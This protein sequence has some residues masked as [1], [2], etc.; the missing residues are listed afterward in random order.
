MVGF[1]AMVLSIGFLRIIPWLLKL[2][3]DG[4]RSGGDSG[5]VLKFVVGMVA[6]AALGGFFLYLQRWLII[7]ASR[8]VEFD[9]KN[10]LFK[11]L[12]SMDVDYFKRKKTGELL[13]H[14]TNDLNA[15]RDV[16]GPGIMYIASM[17]MA[18]IVSLSLM[19][20][21]D[22]ILT[23]VAFSPYPLISIITIYFGRAMHRRSRAVQDQFGRL[24]T[25]VQEDIAGIRVIRSYGQEEN[26]VDRFRLESSAYKDA[27]M[28]VARLRGRFMAGMGLLAGLGL[29]LSLLVGGGSV[30]RGTLSLGSL[31]AFTA[32]LTELLWPV[33]AVGFVISMIQRG[34]SAANRLNEVYEVSP[35]ILSGAITP[36]RI[37]GI[38]FDDVSFAYPGD[39]RPAL[40]N[41]RFHV[42]PGETLG[43]V[44]RTGSGKSTILKLI[45]RF[46]D[47]T[48]GTIFLNDRD[49]R[50]YSIKELR[51]RI[52]YAPQDGFLFS[53][54]IEDNIAYGIHDREE[55]DWKGA[56]HRAQ[57]SDEIEGFPD[58][59]STVVGERGIALSGGQRQRVSLAR[60]LLQNPT[61]LVLD[62]TLS[63]VDAETEHAILDSLSTEMEHKTSIIVSHRLSAVA[64]AD[65]II[66]LDDGEIIEEGTHSTLLE[67]NGFYAR[68]WSRQQLKDELEHF[69]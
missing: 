40:R 14:F 49:L 61:V 57:L 11:H 9:L 50:S 63:S 55:H 1:A 5:D 62:D 15:L 47:P 27:N 19:I 59:Y 31:V 56:A 17:S 4:I 43:I 36:K 8:Y 24:S 69:S 28:S 46:Y 41:L 26:R 22:P 58:E 42:N 7:G 37:A 34:S 67:G 39:D 64:D 38:Q 6:A 29:A 68:L 60:A 2:S 65:R 32:Y 35:S 18:L 12:Q 48:R 66:V 10:D 45:M 13:A 33:I 51:A 21:L 44:G 23:L 20:A 25:R 16:A 30:I 52:G 3:I 54:S 53:R